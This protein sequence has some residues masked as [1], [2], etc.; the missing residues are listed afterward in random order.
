MIGTIRAMYAMEAQAPVRMDE[1]PKVT[2]YW[3]KTGTGKTRKVFADHQGVWKMPA[4]TKGGTTWF[5]SYEGQK[6]VLIDDFVGQ[7]DPGEMLHLL[8]RYPH[9]VQVKCDYVD[10]C[11]LEIFITSNSLPDEWW[12]DT[13]LAEETRA[14][15]KRRI[16][17][18]VE[19]V[20]V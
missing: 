6:V 3:G 2:L 8:D 7:I 14:A 16:H 5:D 20:S 10:W 12:M 19:I 15:I 1:G 18:V 13:G 11:P 9:K 4:K 17:K